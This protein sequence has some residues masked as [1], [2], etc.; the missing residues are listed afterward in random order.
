MFKAIIVKKIEF[1]R[2]SETI[3]IEEDTE[4][5]IKDL[6]GSMVAITDNRAFD[7]SPDEYVKLSGPVN[8]S[9]H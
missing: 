9:A 3:V 2:G 5:M 6:G 7:V 1:S 4:V 8:N